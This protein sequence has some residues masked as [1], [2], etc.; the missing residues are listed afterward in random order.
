MAGLIKATLILRH[1]AIP[2]SLH[3]DDPN[4]RIGLAALNLR[5]V[6]E[7]TPLPQLGGRAIVG[8]NSFGFGGTNAHVVLEEYPAGEAS[9]APPPTAGNAAFHPKARLLTCSLE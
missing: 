4:P 7:V 6:R 2:P 8:V 1:G 9:A 5:I 3:C